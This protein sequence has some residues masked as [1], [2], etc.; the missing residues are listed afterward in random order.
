MLIPVPSLCRPSHPPQVLKEMLKY[1]MIASLTFP[2][3]PPL[4]APTNMAHTAP[5]NIGAIGN[6]D[7]LQ[8]RGN[9][10]SVE[11]KIPNVCKG[12]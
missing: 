8:P 2:H 12:F 4:L 10:Q 7:K 6:T 1:R 9:A 11:R 3:M 5:N